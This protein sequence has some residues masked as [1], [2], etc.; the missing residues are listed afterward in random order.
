[1][2]T[3]P[4]TWQPFG[5]ELGLS[6]TDWESTCHLAVLEDHHI[7]ALE[8]RIQSS[9]NVFHSAF[10]HGITSCCNGLLLL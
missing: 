3:L 2:P 1:M 10:G 9:D 7:K 8:I 5:W 4:T 6:N